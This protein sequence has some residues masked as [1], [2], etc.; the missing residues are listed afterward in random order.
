MRITGSV[1]QHGALFLL[2]LRPHPGETSLATLQG[3]CLL[4]MDRLWEV[5]D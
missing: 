5:D 1:Q 3:P 2:L 4:L